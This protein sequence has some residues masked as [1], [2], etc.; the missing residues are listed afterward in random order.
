MVLKLDDAAFERL[1][2]P[3]KFKAQTIEIARRLLVGGEEPRDLAIAYGLTV[4]R[5]YGIAQQ[6]TAAYEAERLPAG[7]VE[8]TLVAPAEL[9]EK[10]QAMLDAYPQPDIN[11]Q[12]T[13][14]ELP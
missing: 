2:R 11:G 5:V 6:F 9:V 1:I 12:A 7:W 8:V 13:A 14:K 4:P 10:F 3:R